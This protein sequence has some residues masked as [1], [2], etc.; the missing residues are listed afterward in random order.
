VWWEYCEILPRLA[1]GVLVHIHD[2]SL[3]KPY[4]DVY[5]KQHRYWNEQYLL[6]AFL[7][8][9]PKFEVIWAGNYM[10]IQQPERLRE[11]F[12]PEYDH[13][14]AKFPQSEPSAFWMRV[15]A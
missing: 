5:L 11:Q 7:T 12:L 14:R 10:M 6:Q 2:I 3:P 13:M 15:K 8:F 4:P 9:N 1:P